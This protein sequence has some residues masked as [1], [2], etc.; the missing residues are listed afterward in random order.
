MLPPAF[1]PPDF[2]DLKLLCAV[3]DHRSFSAAARAAG[4]T[5]SR[6]S[7]AIARLEKRLGIPLVRRSS[8]GLST[9]AEA[10]RYATHARH[11]LVE[12]QALEADIVAREA[13]L[14]G[15][16]RVSAPPALSRRVL[17]P[18]FASFC[19]ESPQ[20]RLELSLA[21]RRVR[22]IEEHVHVAFRFGP[23]DETW[24]LSRRIMSG[25]Y[26]VYASPSL[27]LKPL[28][29]PDE[30]LG[31]PSL[32]LHSTDLR[33]RWPLVF[34]GQET[35][36]TVTP[37]LLVDDVEALIGFAVAGVGV[38]MLPD[39]LVEAEVASGQLVP[40]TS[41]DQAVPA[42]FIPSPHLRRDP[43]SVLSNTSLLIY[44]ERSDERSSAPFETPGRTGRHHAQTD[45]TTP[46][47][48]VMMI[49]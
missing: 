18:L 34:N 49:A 40:L 44:V 2:E 1:R 38:T 36:V 39:F 42:K 20:I 33:N 27:G 25:L 3:V 21:A 35:Q 31:W 17:L 32:V 6:V 22:L 24:Q 9:T 8:R 46:A 4:T 47:S 16:L 19:R 30:V 43:P 5:Q 29:E 13:D 48:K 12:L 7:R 10:E 23:L 26:R 11:V 41:E 15:P 28:R 37:T 45:Q 14:C